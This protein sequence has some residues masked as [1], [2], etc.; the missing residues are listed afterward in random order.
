[1]NTIQKNWKLFLAEGI[2]FVLLGIFAIA[3]PAVFTLT[4]ELLIGW[5]LIFAGIALA[6]RTFQTH[7]IQGY[8]PSLFLGIIYFITGILLLMYPL[9]GILTLTVLL[10]IFFLVDGIGKIMAG[11]QWRLFRNW[12]WMVFSGVLSI[13]MALIIWL[14][15]PG[16][17][18]WVIG[19]LFGINMLFFGWSLI[20]LALTF[21][22]GSA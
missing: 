14:G 8:Y 12:G 1:M 2:I 20:A 17:A 19:L 15:L 7:P 4:I 10:G 21:R 5:L 9:K 13:L 11:F 6:V 3:L 22:K 18:A 16:T